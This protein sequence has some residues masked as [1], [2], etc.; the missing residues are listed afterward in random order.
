MEPIRYILLSIEI[1]KYHIAM[2]QFEGTFT[3]PQYFYLKYLP[4][5]VLKVCTKCK[6]CQFLRR[7]KKQYGGLP[8]KEVATNPWDTLCVDLNG[9]HQFTP[10]GGG[11]KF[12]ILQKG[13]EKK[14]K[15]TTRSG[16]SMYLKAITIID[17]AT[18]W[19]KIRTVPSARADTRF[20]LSSKVIVDGRSKFLA[21]FREIIIEN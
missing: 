4:E 7:N 11:K 21:R 14:Y 6:A 20:P 8:P 9:K 10:K 12:Q 2:Y 18:G 19:I 3:E 5:I 17:P 15:M 16:K 13:D 1:A